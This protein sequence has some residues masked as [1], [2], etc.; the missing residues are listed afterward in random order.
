MTR[1]TDPLELIA[2]R[3]STFIDVNTGKDTA[4]TQPTEELKQTI[5]EAR[6]I[7]ATEYRARIAELEHQ[8]QH[9]QDLANK[10]GKELEEMRLAIIE[11]EA[12]KAEVPEQENTEDTPAD[13]FFAN[14]ARYLEVHG[15]GPQQ[16]LHEVQ[17]R[18]PVERASYFA[19][20]DRVADA[21]QQNTDN[22]RDLAHRSRVAAQMV[23]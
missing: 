23:E 16:I 10:R 3:R 11:L 9:Y 5:A 13:S 22:L 19:S 8:V 21:M 12:D 18:G 6:E 17:R 4:V 2:P 20:I 15:N 7:Q 14:V 1:K